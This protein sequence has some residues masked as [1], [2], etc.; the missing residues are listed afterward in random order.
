MCVH[1][2][3]RVATV[4]IRGWCLFKE[5]HLNQISLYFNCIAT[6]EVH[7]V[8][9]SGSEALNYAKLMFIHLWS[10]SLVP[11]CVEEEMSLRTR[12]LKYCIT[13][14]RSRV[15]LVHTSYRCIDTGWMCV[16]SCMSPTP[17][18]EIQWYCT[19]NAATIEN[20]KTHKTWYITHKTRWV[21]LEL[22]V[23]L[24]L[25]CLYK[26]SYQLMLFSYHFGLAWG[27]TTCHVFT[28]FL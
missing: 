6:F 13:E 27:G 20:T 10:A 16:W 12:L 1:V 26:V 11:R 22:L 24:W 8:V 2:L 17:L 15:G 19:S 18:M 7:T 3:C 14:L 23:S 9:W 4:T 21:Y 5:I 28:C 25:V